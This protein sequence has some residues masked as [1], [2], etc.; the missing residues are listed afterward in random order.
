MIFGI[1]VIGCVN[2]KVRAAVLVIKNAFVDQPAIIFV[3]NDIQRLGSA[4]CSVVPRDDFVGLDVAAAA[5]VLN[6]SFVNAEL[7]SSAARRRLRRL[8]IH[9]NTATSRM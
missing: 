7:L 1:A 3:V 4:R 8:P 5:V 2:F 6:L 9:D